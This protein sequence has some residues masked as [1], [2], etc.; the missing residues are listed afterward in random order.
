MGTPEQFSGGNRWARL[1]KS[2]KEVGR[3]FVEDNSKLTFERAMRRINWDKFTKE[4]RCQ[5]VREIFDGYHTT[6]QFRVPVL[7]VYE[8]D[9]YGDWQVNSI[10]SV[11]GILQAKRRV[12]LRPLSPDAPQLEHIIKINRKFLYPLAIRMTEF[13]TE[14]GERQPPILD[15]G[16][17]RTPF[18]PTYYASDDPR[19]SRISKQQ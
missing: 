5:Q 15:V 16:I 9:E 4:Q 1:R 12:N 6:A 7:P 19:R 2:L 13:S 18:E 3:N 11:D 8:T 10:L 17:F 14:A